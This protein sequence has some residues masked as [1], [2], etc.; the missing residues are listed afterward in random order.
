MPPLKVSFQLSLSLGFEKQ[1][2]EFPSDE[3]VHSQAGSVGAGT[4][5]VGGL[6]T[7]SGPDFNQQR[8]LRGGLLNIAFEVCSGTQLG[9][10]M[11]IW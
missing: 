4:P 5:E 1:H 9:H 8:V 6:V 10:V 2:G 7:A 3:P 11:A